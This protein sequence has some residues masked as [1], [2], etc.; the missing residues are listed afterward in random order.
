MPQRCI[1]FSEDFRVRHRLGLLVFA[2]VLGACS[3]NRGKRTEKQLADL[4]S[5]QEADKAAAKEK[6]EKRLAPVE[7]AKLDPPYDESNTK[8]M[9]DAPCPDGLWAL[10][11]GETPGATPEEKKANAAKRPELVKSLTGKRFMVRLRAPQEVVLKPHDAAQGILPIEVN[12]TIDCTDSI[13]HI[14]IAWTQ[15]KAGTPEASAAKQA[16]EF[17]QNMWIAPP[18]LVSLPMKSMSEAKEFSQ[19]SAL[20]LSARVVFTLGK[21]EVDK[22]IRKVGKVQETVQ[23]ETVG[24]GGG[25]EDWG[26]GR[27]IRAEVVALRVATDQEKK[28]LYEVKGP[29]K[30]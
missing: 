30:P 18:V 9:A 17:V 3:E 24:Y 13:G 1:A 29:L 10:F 12:G 22:K 7:A 15:A 19:N 2:V 23:T 21:T 16:A 5:K 6:A 20:G 11:P 14:A 27:L 25:N 28:Q 26:A 4:K 8:I